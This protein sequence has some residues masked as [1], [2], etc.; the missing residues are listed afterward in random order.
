M[1]KRR[2]AGRNRDGMTSKRAIGGHGLARTLSKLGICSRAEAWRRIE[3]GRVR[4]NGAT[5]RDPERRVNP[6]R[7]RIEVDGQSVRAAKKVYL[8]LNKPRGLVTTAS[9]EH[10]RTTVFECLRGVPTEHLVAV[11]RLDK[12]SEGLLL[13]TNDTAWAARITDPESKTAKTYHVQVNASVDEL[14]CRRLETGV[15]VGGE[16]LAAKRVT[17]VRSGG[18]TTWLEILLDEGRNR[19]IRRLLEASGFEVLRLV[20]IR[21]G[22]LELGTLAKG[23]Y[24]TLTAGE[25]A[26]ATSDAETPHPVPLPEGEGLEFGGSRGLTQSFPLPPV[27]A[28]HGFRYR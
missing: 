13:L 25:V 23:A 14:T 1:R 11:G 18:K 26:K 9:D 8:A 10:G 2:F 7:D 4:V 17:V 6:E 15:D 28:F 21:I 12:A 5:C 27:E 24:R 19:H 16:R 22:D 3:A 20:R